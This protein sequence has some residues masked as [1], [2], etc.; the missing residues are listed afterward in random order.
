M[1]NKLDERSTQIFIVTAMMSTQR[2]KKYISMAEINLIN[3][4][5]SP[6][7]KKN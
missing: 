4:E 3:V 2:E 1:L 5:L 6:N 7:Y